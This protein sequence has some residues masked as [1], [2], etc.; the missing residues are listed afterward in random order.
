MFVVRHHLFGQCQLVENKHC[1]VLFPRLTR[2]NVQCTQWRIS[3]YID[4]I[5]LT[6]DGSSGHVARA[7]NYIDY[8][9]FWALPWLRGKIY[10]FFSVT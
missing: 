3:K 9:L 1:L 6:L 4:I 7:W 5:P 2:T 10:I 8:N